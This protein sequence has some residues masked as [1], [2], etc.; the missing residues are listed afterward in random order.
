MNG[1][2][3]AAMHR[4]KAAQHLGVGGIDDGVH[5]E[6]GDVA[7]PFHQTL[8]GNLHNAFIYQLCLQL[9]ILRLQELLGDRHRRP[10]IQQRTHQLLS[11]LQTLRNS[12][13]PKPGILI[14]QVSA[15]P[16][17][18]VITVHFFSL[19]ASLSAMM[20]SKLSMDHLSRLSK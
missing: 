7:L 17:Y 11:L 8:F 9:C 10:D 4:H 1:I 15:N 20:A 6:A 2:V 3:D 5:L 16:A 18:V 12:Q 14:Q 13:I 19:F